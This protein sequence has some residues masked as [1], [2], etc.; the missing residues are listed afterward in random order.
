MTELR[1]R[2]ATALFQCDNGGIVAYLES[3]DPEVLDT[4]RVIDGTVNFAKLA[5]AVIKEL[6]LTE[7][8]IEPVSGAWLNKLSKF[9]SGPEIPVSWDDDE[10]NTP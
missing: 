6:E 3:D 9:K 7:I 2:I 4:D 1:Q 5:D 10:L 8:I